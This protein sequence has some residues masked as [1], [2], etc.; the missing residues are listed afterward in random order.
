[1]HNPMIKIKTVNPILQTI[2][3]FEQ[4]SVYLERNS[5]HVYFTQFKIPRFI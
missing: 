2:S 4:D 3:I 5:A 1:M